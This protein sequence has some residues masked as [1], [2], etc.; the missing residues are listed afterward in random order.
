MRAALYAGFCALALREAA[1][2]SLGL[3]LPAAS[4]NLPAELT[5]G[6]SISAYLVLQAVGFAVPVLSPEPR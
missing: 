1:T 5:L 4:S 2:I 3:P 6:Q